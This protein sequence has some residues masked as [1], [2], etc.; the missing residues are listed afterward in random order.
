[1]TTDPK[2]WTTIVVPCYNEATRL[3][4]ARFREFLQRGLH[5]RFLFVNDASTD[6][7]VGV[8]EQLRIGYES[9]IE[10]HN[11]FPNGGKADAVRVG[12]LI[13]MRQHESEY[14]GFWDAD[15]ATPLDE[16]PDFIRLLDIHPQLDMVFGSRVR[17]LGRAIHRKAARHYLG[18]IFATTVSTLLRLP[19]YDTQCGAKLFR[20]DAITESL[21][22][23]PFLSRWIF[24]VEI[25]ARY[26]SKQSS[27]HAVEGKIY[28]H[29]LESWNDVAGSKVGPQAFFRAFFDLI[30]IYRAYQKPPA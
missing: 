16:I 5:V 13:A 25:L 4:L 27:V 21:F 19:I 7:T 2:G 18:R 30:R 20:A 12:I 11:K 1:M 10:L 22:A 3:D 9:L 28:E 6:D 15:L 14:V 23:S 29:P 8:I 17:L 26:I 24:D